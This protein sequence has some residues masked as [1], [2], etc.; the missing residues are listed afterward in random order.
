[1]MATVELVS[2][3]LDRAGLSDEQK[4]MVFCGNAAR[5]Y[6]IDI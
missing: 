1:M 4:A 5:F 6:A 3:A 2:A